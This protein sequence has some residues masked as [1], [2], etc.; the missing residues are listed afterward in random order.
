MRQYVQQNCGK[1]AYWTV[2][3]VYLN[4]II[5]QKF[6]FLCDIGSRI[7]FWVNIK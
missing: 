5:S 1:H 2:K 4:L 7:K 6:Y 3:K